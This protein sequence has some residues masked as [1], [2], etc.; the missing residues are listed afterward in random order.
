MPVG[1]YQLEQAAADNMLAIASLADNAGD[2]WNTR[3]IC[4]NSHIE[5]LDGNPVLYSEWQPFA[6][7]HVTT[8]LIPIPEGEN[9]NPNWHIRLHKLTCMS[10][11]QFETAEAG[12]AIQG[13]SSVSGRYLGP[14]DAGTEEGKIEKM[15]EAIAISNAGAVGI[16][17]L[18]TKVMRNGRVV[19]ADPNSNLV[20]SRTL[21]PS[22]IMRIG[23]KGEYWL[24]TGVFTLPECVEGWREIW[25]RAW[26]E[27]PVVPGWV[28]KMLE[29]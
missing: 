1:T 4:L 23:G 24:I 14:Y 5:I 15:G 18:Q 3:R 11:R 22:L 29:N 9:K 25:H 10:D 17:E 6:D 19:K 2:S 27:R 7:L 28:K 21:L 8:W 12:F 13:T 20:E 26:Q 16:M